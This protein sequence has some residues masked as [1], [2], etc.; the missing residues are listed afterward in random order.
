MDIK[1]TP[2]GVPLSPEGTPITY[3]AL[4]DL[5]LNTV[6]GCTYVSL[7]MDTEQDIFNKGGRNAPV[8]KD[9]IG[10]DLDKLRKITILVGL[11]SGTKVGYQDFVNNRLDKEAVA[12][13]KEGAQLEFTAGPR[14]WGEHVKNADGSLN[15]ALV[16]HK[17]E[18]YLNFFCL[19]NN[20]PTVLWVYDGNLV[21]ISGSR[22]DLW[23]KPPKKDGQNQGPKSPIVVRTPKF[24]SIRA[25]S[26]YGKTYNP[27]PG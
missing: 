27:I 16:T 4:K 21:D 25:I 13:G 3:T 6:Q 17:G 1:Y 9:A 26:M 5:V 12:D 20:E 8:M 2:E 7:F 22:F 24:S 15:N 19:A 14:P 23:R 11:L 18:F 10:F